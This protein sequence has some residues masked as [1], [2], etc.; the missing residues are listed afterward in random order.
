M[1]QKTNR[2]SLFLLE[3]IVAIAFFCI[4]SAICVQFF[5]RS[6]QLEQDSSNIN[7]AVHAATSIAEEYRLTNMDSCVIYYDETWTECNSDEAVFTVKLDIEDANSLL[8]AHI[9]V[10]DENSTLY[11]LNVLKNANKEVLH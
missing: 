3:L 10:L 7:H 9:M 11:E 2:S 5:V 8:N 6:H 1:L 4:A